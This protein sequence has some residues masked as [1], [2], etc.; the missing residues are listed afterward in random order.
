[1]HQSKFLY[2]H[3][4]PCALPLGYI[5][6]SINIISYFYEKVKIFI[7]NFFNLIPSYIFYRIYF[8]SPLI[9][10]HILGFLSTFKQLQPIT[11]RYQRTPRGGVVYRSPTCR[12]TD[13]P[14][15]RR[16]RS[17]FV[18]SL[19][20]ISQFIIL[21]NI[22]MTNNYPIFLPSSFISPRTILFQQSGQRVE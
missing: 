15:Y 11:N 10:Y 13:K 12:R 18:S 17:Y 2:Y 21:V 14:Q 5:P 16:N 3:S 7:F 20:I 1:M 19:F 6:F 4:K 9:L 22:F 8:Q